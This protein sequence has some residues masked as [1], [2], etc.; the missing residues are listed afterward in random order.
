MDFA[1]FG[2]IQCWSDSLCHGVKQRLRQCVRPDSDS[3]AIGAALD[4][5]RSKSELVLENALLRQQLVVLQ[6]QVK[7][8]A[9][10]CRDRALLVLM[11]SKLPSWRS[12]LMIVQP[13]T[14]LRW[15]REM[16]RR[17]WKR[18]SRRKGRRGRSPLS[19]DVVGLI[20]S[21]AYDNR[22]WGAERI[23]GELLKLGVQVSKSTIQRY[24]NEVRAPL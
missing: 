3:L 19:E 15:H 12:A 23:R 13:D 22:T 16:F 11:A 6:R 8:P 18:K 5:T 17:L 4:L 20:K 10:T 2:F 21:M 1:C 24:M 14:L 9:L 7:R